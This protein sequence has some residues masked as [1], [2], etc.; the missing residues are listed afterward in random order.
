MIEK[1][2]A[3]YSAKTPG[4]SA[5]KMD[6]IE[7]LIRARYPILAIQSW[8]EERITSRLIDL[9]GKLKKRIFGWSSARGL[10]PLDPTSADR[11][12]DSSSTDPQAALHR[13]QEYV[14]P[15]VFMFFDFHAYFKDPAT[16]RLLR[17]TARNFKQSFKTLILVS[18]QLRIP[19]ELEKDITMASF[20]LPGPHDIDA[21]LGEIV[22]ELRNQNTVKVK[23][24]GQDRERLV[25]AALGLTLSEVENVFARAVVS[26]GELSVD[27]LPLII[28]EKEQIIRRSQVLEFYSSSEKF[29][30]VAGLTHLKDWL[31]KRA[32]SFSS[33]AR[34]FGLP[35][36]RGILLIGVQGCGKSLT[37]K[38]V[39]N[40]WR[41]PLLRLDAGA[42]FSSLVGASEEN[43]RRAVTT[44]ES[45][46]PAIMWID[47][48]EKGFAGVQASGKLDAGTSAR[49]FGT[50]ITWL[51]EKTA[52]VFVIATANDITR[53]PA[54]ML[55]KGRFDEIFFI[56]LPTAEERL[57]IF[58]I[59]LDKRG[60][61][62][63]D[64]D[65]DT[66]VTL[67]RDY[68]GAEIENAVISAM[69]DVFDE[70]A[71]LTTDA[72]LKALR[73][74]M[75]LARLME[76]S[77]NNLREWAEG[78]VRRASEKENA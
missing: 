61:N 14:D 20:S 22:R 45:V 15:A 30:Q 47:E 75:P 78:R 21:V 53:L 23:L 51:Q 5:H 26:R 36:P 8:E 6:E 58:E 4:K 29:D 43:L 74:T 63:F 66:L 65:L 46:S 24:E 73:E 68:S 41:M 54:E 56:D 9:A 31:R 64:F 71:P 67:S 69:F 7:I 50:L 42:L 76:E 57:K 49:V 27:A 17:D 19:V 37:A 12:L 3:G 62:P 52:P 18:P 38:A 55:R 77:V 13:I 16:V 59:H 70:D 40:Y 10:H 48:I 28:S 72:L 44:A 32:K 60:F 2:P 35:N 39:A 33:K 1:D 25:Q 11:R 34:E